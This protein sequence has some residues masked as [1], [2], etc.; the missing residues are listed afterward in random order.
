LHPARL[1]LAI[2]AVLIAAVCGLVAI[3]HGRAGVIY[4]RHIRETRRER[5]LVATLGFYVSFAV[6]RLLTHAIRAGW[7]PFHDV[8]MGGRHIH[9]L[10]WGILLLLAVGYGW[11]LQV[12]TGQ[13]R[14]SRWAGR[15][16]SLL[17]GVGAAL[18]LDEFALWLNLRDVYWEREGRASVD[19]VLLFGSLLAIGILGHPFVHALIKEAVR[20]RSGTA[21]GTPPLP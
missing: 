1:A 15:L 19:A 10:V 12:G 17:Y 7:G 14:G 13:G 11:M 16:M 21:S 3:V 6:V 5:L 18:T 9:H 20:V 4:H 2:L 8:E